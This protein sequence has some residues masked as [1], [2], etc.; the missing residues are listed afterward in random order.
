LE[1][2]NNIIKVWGR[3]TSL[4]HNLLPEQIVSQGTKLLTKPVEL[5]LKING[6]YVDFSQVKARIKRDVE[7]VSVSKEQDFD[8]YKAEVILRAEFDGYMWYDFKIFPREKVHID[9]ATLKI[10]PVKENSTLFNCSQRTS[11]TIPRKLPPSGA[12]NKNIVTQFSPFVWFG[13]DKVGLQYF[14]ETDRYCNLQN[15]QETLFLEPG[16][17]K[18]V[19]VDKSFKTE[20]ELNYSFGLMASPIKPMPPRGTFWSQNTIAC[21][22]GP[23]KDFDPQES[24][25]DFKKGALKKWLQ[26]EPLKGCF[27]NAANYRLGQCRLTTTYNWSPMFGSTHTEDPEFNRKFTAFIDATHK[28][29]PEMKIT[30][31]CGWGINKDWSFYRWFGTEMTKQPFALSISNTMLHCPNSSFSDFFTYGVKYMVN[32]YHVDGIYLDSTGNVSYCD[33]LGHGCGYIDSEG[34]RRGHYPIRKMRDLFKR[35]YKVT[36][37]E[38]IDNGVIY[39]HGT[40]PRLPILSFADTYLCGESLINRVKSL[41]SIDRDE[42][43]SLF[44]GDPWGIRSAI[45]WHFFRKHARVLPNQI[46]GFF[47]VNGIFVKCYNANL[48]YFKRQ[49]PSYAPNSRVNKHIYILMDEFSSRKDTTFYPY[50][51]NS[52]Y[53]NTGSADILGSFFINENKQAMLVLCNLE[54]KEQTAQVKFT[55]PSGKKISSITDG[56]LKNNIVFTG[57]NFKVTIGPQGYRILIIK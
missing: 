43:R 46:L 51:N 16:K 21:Q 53:L 32:K 48:M 30:P 5:N 56:M 27:V 18:A 23:G 8:T 25:E 14:C 35:I 47:L 11:R 49:A 40:E 54:N 22:Y 1:Y 13:N 7:G 15:R 24:L 2:D 34:E 28:A 6:K 31:Y 20:Q 39:L 45:C 38:V 55:L 42:F 9:S 52:A 36:H 4:N 26:P 19:F 12:L 41:K 29:V 33:R 44:V 37:G 50:W 17:F 3:E 57:E 10:F